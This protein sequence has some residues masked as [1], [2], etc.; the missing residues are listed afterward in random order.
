M[1][2]KFSVITINYNN[3][4]GLERTFNSVVS[5]T[6]REAVEFIVVDGNSSDGSAEFLKQNTSQINQLIIEK[7]NGLYDAMNK[8]LSA[9]SGEYVWFVNSGDAIYNSN[10]VESLLPLL[11]LNIDVIFGD[12]M[13]I[14]PNGAEIGP[15]SKLK[16]QPL[17]DSLGPSSFRYGMSVCHQSFIVKRKLSPLYDL[18][19]KQAAD[20][21]WIINILENKPKTE[22]Y[23]GIISAFETGGSSYQNEKKAW[24]ERYHVLRKH[25]GVIPNYLAHFW[26]ALRRVLFN[27]GIW[28]P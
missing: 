13:F 5:Q 27:N 3:L 1:P 20:I 15:I 8:G 2:E 21:D 26:I 24:K 23:S 18:N 28:K 4:K 7:D 22:K 25:Y 12:T 16:P 9:A 6:A 11:A 14:E 17:P 10:V 19:F